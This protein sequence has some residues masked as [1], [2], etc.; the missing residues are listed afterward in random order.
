MKVSFNLDNL[1]SAIKE[2]K[3]LDNKLA[4]KK[5]MQAERFAL[6]PTKKRALQL[7]PDKEGELKK[8]LGFFSKKKARQVA[9][10]PEFV[11][12]I[13][14]PRI[15]GKYKGHHAH[16][17]EYGTDFRKPKKRKVLKFEGRNGETI[18]TPIAGRVKPRKFMQRAI[19]ESEIESR[20]ITKMKKLI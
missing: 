11:N 18:F 15:Y 19:N 5:V 12:V 7:I 9:R 6:N 17:I 3:K 1:D 10:N 13:L 4:E 8:A 20:F 16:L 14:G 2:L